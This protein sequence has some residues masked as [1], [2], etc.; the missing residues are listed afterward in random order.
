MAPTELGV[1][2]NCW[3]GGGPIV[4]ALDSRFSDVPSLGLWPISPRQR[5][6]RASKRSEYRDRK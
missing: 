4:V 6:E 1:V 2:P 5:G 3:R